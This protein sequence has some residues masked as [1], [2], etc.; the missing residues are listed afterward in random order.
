ME[1]LAIY[2]ADIGSI[3]AKPTKFGW[4]GV[5]DNQRPEG[6]CIH[7]LVDEIATSLQAG[8]KVALGFECPLWVPVSDGPFD[9]TSARAVDGNKPWSAGAGACA[10]ATGLTESAWILSRVRQCL[11]EGEAAT[12]RAYLD[13]HEFEDSKAGLFVWE[14]FVTGE[15]K[16]K[17]QDK[18]KRHIDDARKACDEFIE[19]LPD[20]TTECVEEPTGPIHSL[21]GGVLLWAGW[22]DDPALLR[23]G[24]LVVRPDA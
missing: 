19:R 15:A 10:L 13:W 14:A 20:P 6:S 4:A 2:C 1:R 7:D 23:T 16:S 22:S 3:K 24:C 17:C 5:H 11:A 8:H 18:A 9:L 21:I 12:T